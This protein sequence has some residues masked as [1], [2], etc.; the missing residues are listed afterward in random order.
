MSCTVD[1]HL[2]EVLKDC[3]IKYKFKEKL[4]ILSSIRD[5]RKKVGKQGRL[6]TPADILV[7]I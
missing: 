2:S 3:S 4:R 6:P 7:N 1:P 5:H